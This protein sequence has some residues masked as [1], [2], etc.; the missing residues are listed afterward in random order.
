MDRTA[1]MRYFDAEANSAI[2]QMWINVRCFDI[3]DVPTG[4]WMALLAGLLAL[5][6]MGYRKSK[7]R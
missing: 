7:R 2:N 4:V 1:V 5:I 6:W 3:Y